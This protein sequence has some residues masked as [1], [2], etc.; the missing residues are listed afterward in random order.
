MAGWRLEGREEGGE[1]RWMDG[2]MKEGDRGCHV[3]EVRGI[4]ATR[5]HEF[6]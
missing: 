5:Q 2:W 4:A 6:V 1:V 3:L